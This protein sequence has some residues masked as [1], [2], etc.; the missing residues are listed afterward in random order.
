MGCLLIGLV[1]YCGQWPSLVLVRF[2]CERGKVMDKPDMR[3]IL[4]Q[5]LDLVL[6]VGVGLSFFSSHSFLL[7]KHK[8]HSSSLS[9]SPFH[10]FLLSSIHSH[11]FLHLH[12]NNFIFLQIY[13]ISSH[14]IPLLSA[15]Y[16]SIIFFPTYAS[17][18]QRFATPSRFF[19]LCSCHEGKERDG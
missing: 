13:S 3:L 14:S 15:P 4:I 6:F 16:N 2:F 9:S 11:P 7:F 19:A 17:N 1:S 8:Y 10:S 12:I 5:A 18:K